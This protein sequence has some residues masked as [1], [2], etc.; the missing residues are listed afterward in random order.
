MDKRIIVSKT[1]DKLKN[2]LKKKKEFRENKEIDYTQEGGYAQ[3]FHLEIYDI[4]EDTVFFIEESSG[5][6]FKAPLKVFLA[7]PG[8]NNLKEKF[9]K[10]EDTE[11]ITCYAK[12]SLDPKS[13]T[14]IIIKNFKAEFNGKKVDAPQFGKYLYDVLD[15]SEILASGSLSDLD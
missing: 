4:S 2:L 1:L 12:I 13:G 9:E 6:K 11:E 15:I 5:H 7:I 3:T 8:F 14:K 10:S